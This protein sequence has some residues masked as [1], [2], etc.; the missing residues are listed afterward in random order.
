MIEIDSIR[1]IFILKYGSWWK[2]GDLTFYLGQAGSTQ[3][4][5]TKDLIKLELWKQSSPSIA[6]AQ[7][8]KQVVFKL[9]RSTVTWIYTSTGTN[10]VLF[11]T[12]LE[13][14]CAYHFYVRFMSG[15]VG[16]CLQSSLSWRVRRLGKGPF[17]ILCCLYV[18]HIISLL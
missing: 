9:T 13:T 5:L 17:I 1:G 3:T 16:T 18:L 14:V 8:C 12:N 11:Q 7:E 2:G 15:L 4:W 6:A 10:L